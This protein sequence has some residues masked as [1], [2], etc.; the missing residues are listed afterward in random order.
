MAG[1]AALP[2]EAISVV[3]WGCGAARTRVDG[4][5]ELLPGVRVLLAQRSSS[6]GPNTDDL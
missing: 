6:A 3:L 5:F 2:Q 4:E 1:H